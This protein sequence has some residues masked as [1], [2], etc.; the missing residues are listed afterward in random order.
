MFRF[1]DDIDDDDSGV[2][3]LPFFSYLDK[4]GNYW[5][6]FS[7]PS[8][9]DEPHHHFNDGKSTISSNINKRDGAANGKGFSHYGQTDYS[10]YDAS[11]YTPEK[12]SDLDSETS[13]SVRHYARKPRTPRTI[14]MMMEKH[15]ESERVRHHSLN[16][17]LKDV[18][19]RVPG[20]DPTAKETKV[21]QMQRIIGYECFLENTLN[22]LSQQLCVPKTC[23]TINTNFI[24]EAIK[25]MPMD[26]FYQSCNWKGADGDEEEPYFTVKRKKH[27]YRL[28]DPSNLLSGNI[29]N[30]RDKIS[31]PTVDSTTDNIVHVYP[32]SPYI[33]NQGINQ[34]APLIYC[35]SGNED[36]QEDAILEDSNWSSQGFNTIGLSSGV[37]GYSEGLGESQESG[38][39]LESQSLFDEDNQFNDIDS[40]VEHGLYKDC[41]HLKNVSPSF[42]KECVS[43]STEEGEAG[44]DLSSPQRDML[45]SPPLRGIWH[46]ASKLNLSGDGDT[47]KCKEMQIV[48][49]ENVL[50]TKPKLGLSGTGAQTSLQNQFS[51]SGLEPY[52]IYSQMQSPVRS[53]GSSNEMTSKDENKRPSYSSYYRVVPPSQVASTPKRVAGVTP[54]SHNFSHTRDLKPATANIRSIRINIVQPRS[55]A[56]LKRQTVVKSYRV[57][58]AV[59]CITSSQP[60]HC[61]SQSSAGN[62]CCTNKMTSVT[63]NQACCHGNNA[64]VSPPSKNKRK[65]YVPLRSPLQTRTNNTQRWLDTA[66][67]PYKKCRPLGDFDS[68]SKTGYNNGEDNHSYLLNLKT[69]PVSKQSSSTFARRVDHRRSTWMNGFM[70]FTQ[71]NRHKMISANPGLHVSHIQKMMGEKWRG[72]TADEKRPYRE[73]ANQ[74][75]AYLLETQQC[76]DQSGYSLLETQQCH[77]QSGYSLLETQ[78]CHDQSGCSLLETQQCHQSGYS[79]LETQQCHDQS[80]YSILVPQEALQ[81]FHDQEQRMP[82]EALQ[83]FH[84]QE[85]RMPQEALQQFHDQEQRMPQEP[86]QQFHDQ[87][88]RMP[89]EA[90]QQFHDQEQ[91]MPQEPLQ[92][93][94]DQEQDNS[95]DYSFLAP[96]EALNTDKIAGSLSH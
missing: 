75:S 52:S 72:M 94:H 20:F 39:K 96:H 16:E 61:A 33:Y 8:T 49:P 91:R 62:A 15:R 37:K 10:V 44:F 89:Q 3:E 55:I 43:A 6:S 85:Q 54:V 81:Q 32:L 80:G 23:L 58:S 29:N 66:E 77:D 60:Q 34:A 31:S 36:L 63:V 82:Q 79:L 50:E 95:D 56:N 13:S 59:P 48:S 30:Q 19:L 4:E 83:Q 69:T 1:I 7:S 45:N 18:C 27:G 51:I 46:S 86:L 25:N 22:T 38:I 53:R 87:E 17:A 40:L 88:Q 78:Q 28:M 65:R 24:T 90:L 57:S 5:G 14:K 26:E 12:V 9:F 67:P 21:V 47:P 11:F 68:A 74:C 92:Q 35:S 2:E 73:K 42:M 64:M 93:C 41:E 70:M 76:H 84:D 71:V